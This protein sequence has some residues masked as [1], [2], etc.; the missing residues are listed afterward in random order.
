MLPLVRLIVVAMVLAT[1]VMPSALAGAAGTRPSHWSVAWA[2]DLPFYG[3]VMAGDDRGTIVVG[4]DGEVVALDA[5]GV[6]LWS[7]HVELDELVNRPAL[8]GDAI[9]VPGRRGMVALDRVT[10]G[11]IWSTDLAAARVAP[12]AAHGRPVLLATVPGGA[13]L[14]IDVVTG[15]ELAVRTLSSPEPD[16]AP[17]LQSTG[18]VSVVAWAGDHGCCTIAGF[19]T[20]GGRM[21]WRRSVTDASTEPLVHEGIVVV[22]MNGRDRTRGR[23]VALDA[24]NGMP[25]WRTAVRGEFVPGLAGDAVEDLVVVP[26][27]AG[28]VIAADADDGAIR[29]QSEAVTAAERAHAMITSGQVFLT[30]HSTDLVAFDR[31]NGSVL[32]GGPIEQTVVITDSTVVAGHLQLLVTNGFESQVWNVDPEGL[33]TD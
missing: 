10:G 5:D 24:R 32:S 30:P 22:A 9:V 17:L 25:K 20:A 23:V 2:A 29:W 15:D 14:T 26:T 19:A 12:G 8:F 31:A 7:T 18:D 21:L 33:R 11:Q 28:A 6:R 3:S 27:K 13:L 4:Y 16:G 1:G